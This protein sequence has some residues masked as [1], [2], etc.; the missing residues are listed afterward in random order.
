MSY[1]V[2][3]AQDLGQAF[4]VNSHGKSL[5]DVGVLQV[6]VLSLVELDVEGSPTWVESITLY[7]LKLLALFSVQGYS[8]KLV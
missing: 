5:T 3:A 6:L 1:S 7:A 4:P 8:V 2:A